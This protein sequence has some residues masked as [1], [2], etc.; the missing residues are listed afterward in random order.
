MS[1]STT[2]AAGSSFDADVLSDSTIFGHPRGLV[3]LFSPS[4]S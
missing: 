1:E 4:V 3:I 2:T